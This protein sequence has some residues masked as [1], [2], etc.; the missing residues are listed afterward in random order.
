ML[1]DRTWCPHLP[2]SERPLVEALHLQPGW[3]GGQHATLTA[4]GKQGLLDVHGQQP[5]PTRPDRSV[6][7][8][9]RGAPIA[10]QST[11]FIAGHRPDDHLRTDSG[12]G[13]DNAT[14]V[15]LGLE[16]RYL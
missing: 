6:R 9:G 8:F 10:R 14:G 12:A 1:H 5:L 7:S 2:P 3:R 11:K 13:E 16:T 15:T 4:E